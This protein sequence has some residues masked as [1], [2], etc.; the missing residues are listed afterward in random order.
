MLWYYYTQLARVTMKGGTVV[1]PLFWEFFDD[2][3]AYL[4]TE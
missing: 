1:R 3:T 4:K 2:E